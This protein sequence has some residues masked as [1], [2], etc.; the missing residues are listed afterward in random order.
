MTNNDDA[1][2]KSYFNDKIVINKTVKIVNNL[3]LIK[4]PNL[5]SKNKVLTYLTR[6]FSEPDFGQQIESHSKII[7]I[8]KKR[9]IRIMKESFLSKTET[10]IIAA[11]LRI[12]NRL[13]TFSKV[14]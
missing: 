12:K 3:F 4:S 8:V 1:G 13:N 11:T 5:N 10:A 9:K 7:F 2:R 6:E 14:L